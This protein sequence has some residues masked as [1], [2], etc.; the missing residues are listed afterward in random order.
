MSSL[1]QLTEEQKQEMSMVDIAFEIM[2]SSGKP[3]HYRDLLKEISKIKGMSDEKMNEVMAQVYTELNIDGRFVC[4]GQ[5]TWGLKR[6]YPVDQQEDAA[7]GFMARDDMD[8]DLED[9]IDEDDDVDVDEAFDEDDDEE[10][11][12]DDFD[13]DFEEDETEEL[14][15]EFDEDLDDEAP[16][17]TDEDD[18]QI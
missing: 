17:D 2:M 14:D 5:N 13:D 18:E 4:V 16:I 11:D 1:N 6:W 15:E 7:E 9:I 3:Y 8:D 10:E 12:D